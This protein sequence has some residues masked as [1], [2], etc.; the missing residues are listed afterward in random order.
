MNRIS[1][2]KFLTLND[3]SSNHLSIRSLTGTQ[4]FENTIA[5][6]HINRPGMNLFG[7]FDNFGYDR[8]QVF[9]RG[10]AGYVVE[11]V[12]AGNFATIDK[13]FEYKIPLCVFTNSNEPPA[14]FIER[15]VKN[16]VP[17]FVS[18][19][20]TGDFIQKLNTLLED[21]FAPHITVHGVFVEVFG[22]GVL[23]KGKSGV[24]KSEAALELV[25]RGHRLIAD[26]SVDF[27]CLRGLIIEGSSSRVLKYNMEI[28]GLGI[29]NIARLSGMSAVR[30][31]KRL[32][33]IVMLEDWKED[34]EYDRTGLEDHT[35]NIL[36][37]EVP[38][39][40]VPV[41]PGR[42][43]HILIETAAK[44][45]RLKKLGYHSAKEFNKRVMRLFEGEDDDTGF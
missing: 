30:D 16:A 45:E 8:L 39:L 13:I 33:L 26:D 35:E 21:E 32:E 18:S 12:N 31:K 43:I 2:E 25:Q 15:A 11:L 44:N 6:Y 10:E 38:S 19:L 27:K 34:K 36:G 28:R 4:G 24:G 1:I 14:A 37:V 5:S 40:T 29:I 22:V 23:L 42:N 17:V 20:T 41:R 7:Y 3:R 9:G